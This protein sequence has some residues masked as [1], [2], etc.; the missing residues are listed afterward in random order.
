MRETTSVL[1]K[2]GTQYPLNTSLERHQYT[3]LLGRKTPKKPL[4]TPRSTL[5]DNI[6]TDLK[7]IEWEGMVEIRMV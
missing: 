2:I 4:G 1:A 5:E 3:S 7:E 6:K